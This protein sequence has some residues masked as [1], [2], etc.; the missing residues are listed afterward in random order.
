MSEIGAAVRRARGH[1]REPREMCRPRTLGG[2][3]AH[4]SG[5]A[6]LRQQDH[7]PASTLR[8]LRQ[9]EATIGAKRGVRRS[10]PPRPPR[11]TGT[12][13]TGA[14]STPPGRREA[15][16]EAVARLAAARGQ[17]RRRRIRWRWACRQATVAAAAAADGWDGA[18]LSRPW[19]GR[20]RRRTLQVAILVRRR[21]RRRRRLVVRCTGH[22]RARADDARS[23]QAVLDAAL[24]APPRAGGVADA[25]D[26]R[27]ARQPLPALWRRRRRAGQR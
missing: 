21:R 16:A 25:V 9:R 26:A 17:R 10:F 14:A 23:A 18:R 24:T 1:R 27:R 22:A 11:C 7:H 8:R 5:S 4:M 20:L 3:S 15:P 13:G 12:N 2:N 19:R 6:W